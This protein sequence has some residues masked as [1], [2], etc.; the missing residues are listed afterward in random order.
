MK[1]LV[2]QDKFNRNYVYKYELKRFIL[3][4]V[5]KNRKLLI[6]IRCKAL[7]ELSKMSKMSSS[8]YFSNRCIFTGRRKRINKLYSFSRIMFL[9]FAR[10][11]FVNGLKKASW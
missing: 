4:N 2:K 6:D 1:K 3:K 8:I 9:K 7:L 5:M 10:Y 11:G